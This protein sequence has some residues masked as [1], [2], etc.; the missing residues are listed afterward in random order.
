MKRY[1]DILVAQPG[2]GFGNAR[3]KW[4]T[5]LN[6]RTMY[7]QIYEGLVD[8]KLAT[9]LKELVYMDQAGNI[10]EKEQKY[11]RKVTHKFT[12]PELVLVFYETGGDT[13]M[14]K[15]GRRGS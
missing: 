4:C 8:S 11:G 13:N 7:D 2:R 3:H 14:E 12:H 9:C 1:Q 6:F 10:V 5:Y 15:D